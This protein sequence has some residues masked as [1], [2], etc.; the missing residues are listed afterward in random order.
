ME[1]MLV[2]NFNAS[3]V[4]HLIDEASNII[5]FESVDVS[6]SSK[7]SSSTRTAMI[8]TEVL[9]EED[10][11]KLDKF[12]AAACRESGIVYIRGL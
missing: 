7:N 3:Y 12:F 6:Y 10:L 4:D 8:S 11:A 1:Y 2:G 9:T 5:S